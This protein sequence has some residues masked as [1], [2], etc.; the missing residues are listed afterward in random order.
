MRSSPLLALITLGW[1][2]CRTEAHADPVE[3]EPI[4]LALFTEGRRL[5][6]DGDI[7]AGCKKFEAARDLVGWLG[8]QL[9]LADCYERIGKTASAWM[10]FLKASDE[11]AKLDDPREVYARSRADAL[12]PRLARVTLDGAL[13][14]GVNVLF[15]RKP[16]TT[17]G[18]A[19]PIPVD[20]GEHLVEASAAGHQSWTT[21]VVVGRSA[22]VRVSVPPLDVAYSAVQISSPVPSTPARRGLVLTLAGVGA[23]S[24][25]TSLL[26]GLD[27]KLRYDDVVG[28]HCTPGL[29]CDLS[30]IDG[31]KEAKRRGNVA[32][33]VGGVGLTAIAA[34]VIVYLASPR[35][36]ESS[37]ITATPTAG[38][39]TVGISI[40]GRM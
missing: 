17:A 6:A 32:T 11:A 5:V 15:D 22:S 24:I 3:D 1:A 18:V 23:I 27:A 2:L 25:G 31:I 9:N 40:Q 21:V 4:A 36:S 38:A 26:L 30:G 16:V 7:E 8:I 39:G 35:G 28:E 10:L 19:V 13:V 14:P 33:V 37:S 34:A 29:A 12:E 20:P